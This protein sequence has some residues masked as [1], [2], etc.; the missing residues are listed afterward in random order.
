MSPANIDCS[1]RHQ[2]GASSIG[3]CGI[4]SL[5]ILVVAFRSPSR[6]FW[7][8]MI[9]V[10]LLPLVIAL[11][12]RSRLLA[13]AKI[14]LASDPAAEAKMREVVIELNEIYPVGITTTVIPLL[15]ILIASV[16][17]ARRRNRVRP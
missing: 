9:V 16:V 10:S 6:K 4:I 8:I 7:F 5:L 1:I 3:A 2:P 12:D 11:V 17:T 14:W 15:L 13:Q